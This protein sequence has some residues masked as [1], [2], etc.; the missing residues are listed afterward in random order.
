MKKKIVYENDAKLKI[1]KGIEKL[2]NAV[3]ITLGPKGKNVAIKTGYNTPVIIN[4]GVSIAKEI[5]LDDEIE[6]VGAQ[7]IKE[8]SQKTND[9]AGDGTTTA[10]V[11]A[12]FM[13][14]NGMKNISGRNGPRTFPIMMKKRPWPESSRPMHGTTTSSASVPV[15][16]PSWRSGRSPGG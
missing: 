16:L 9:I 10:T 15:P 7:L 14:K 6:N 11:L 1:L 12:Y 2:Y 8:A 5:V 13:V 4:D 3:G